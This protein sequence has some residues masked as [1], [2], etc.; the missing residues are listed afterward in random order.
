MIDEEM[1][2]PARIQTHNLRRI[3]SYYF[4][5]RLNEYI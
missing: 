2:L 4:K 1:Q 5:S 3:V